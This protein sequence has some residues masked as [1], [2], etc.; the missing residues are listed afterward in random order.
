MYILVTTRNNWADEIDTQGFAVF[1]PEAWDEHLAKAEKAFEQRGS[2]ELYIGT[3]EEIP[4]EDFND[5]KDQM[6][7]KSIDELQWQTLKDLF[8]I[9]INKSFDCESA[10]GL[11][12]LL[13]SYIF[14]EEE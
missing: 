6:V 12:T 1:M 4:L 9:K 14:D 7:V 2:I 3:N 11:I 10:F 8:K 13:H 5:Y